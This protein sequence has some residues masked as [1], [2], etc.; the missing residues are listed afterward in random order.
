M[1]C[2]SNQK[3]RELSNQII[4]SFDHLCIFHLDQVF[5]G[6]ESFYPKLGRFAM[7]LKIPKL[8][9]LMVQNK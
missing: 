1:L 8:F 9:S 3:R 6:F 5:I 2:P 4:A 7:F